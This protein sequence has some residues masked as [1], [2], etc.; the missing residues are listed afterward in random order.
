MLVLVVCVTAPMLFVPVGR[1]AVKV[2]MST[3]RLVLNGLA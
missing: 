1:E 3:G 2:L